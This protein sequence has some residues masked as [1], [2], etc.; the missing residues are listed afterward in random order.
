MLRNKTIDCFMLCSNHKYN[1]LE[2]IL[3]RPTIRHQ[4]KISLT[5]GRGR[6]LGMYLQ[7]STSKLRALSYFGARVCDC[8]WKF[9]SIKKTAG[10]IE[11]FVFKIEVQ[12][13]EYYVK[14]NKIKESCWR[15]LQGG[16]LS[17][18]VKIFSNLIV[19]FYTHNN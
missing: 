3:S 10:V 14:P 11:E 6:Y 12:I 15:L 8:L 9:G 4:Y 7:M 5:S 17:F 19:V 1:N 2:T 13:L 16:L 18:Y